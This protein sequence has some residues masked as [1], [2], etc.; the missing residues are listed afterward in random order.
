MKRALLVVAAVLIVGGGVALAVFSG[1][2]AP[3]PPPPKLS[4][5]EIRT[6]AGHVVGA[7]LTA[8]LTLLRSDESRRDA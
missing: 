5:G 1:G 6:L 3:P 4:G 7:R 8:D 2:D